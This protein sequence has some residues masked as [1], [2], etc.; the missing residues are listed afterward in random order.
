MPAS[1]IPSAMYSAVMIVRRRGL[2]M[3]C[4]STAHGRKISPNRREVVQ[5][6]SVK[7][8][9]S[10]KVGSSFDI[11][12]RS[13]CRTISST[14]QPR[15]IIACMSVSGISFF[16]IVSMAILYQIHLMIETDTNTTVV[17]IVVDNERGNM[18]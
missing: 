6:D 17:K 13:A 3:N 1:P 10:P 16:P 9:V 15:S 18:L 11:C 7:G 14:R 4:T 5:P 2:A 12:G 8:S